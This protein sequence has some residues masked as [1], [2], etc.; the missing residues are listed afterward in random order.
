MTGWL[1]RK[2]GNWNGMGWN[3]YTGEANIGQ[4]RL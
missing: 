2:R 1:G 4:L 3:Y